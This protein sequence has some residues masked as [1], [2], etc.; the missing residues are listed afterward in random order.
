VIISIWAQDANG[1]IGKDGKMPW[2]L[3]EDLQHFKNRTMKYPVIMGRV[4][5]DALPKSVRP[6]PGRAN[7]VVMRDPKSED[8]KRIDDEGAVTL[9]LALA[10]NAAKTCRPHSD[11]YIIGGASIYAE[12]M[13]VVD[14]L[15]VTQ[16]DKAFDVD[17]YAPKI[18]P[19][20]WI[21]N[22]DVPWQTSEKGLKWRVVEYT[23]R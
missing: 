13:D 17:C 6:L 21:A 10:M 22:A 12:F 16:I 14:K 7:F 2:Y 11:I 9:D 19:A 23:R 8:A 4:S 15:V 3:P 18:D 20:A 1:G 5:Y